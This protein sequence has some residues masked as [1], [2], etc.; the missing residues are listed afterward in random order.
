[1][2]TTD[3]LLQEIK[4]EIK[5][6]RTDMGKRMDD[7]E[8][9]V[10]VCE[11]ATKN[12]IRTMRRQQATINELIERMNELAKTDA[13]IWHSRDNMVIGLDCG[14]AY[15][16]FRELG[17]TRYDALK[18]LEATGVLKRGYGQ[19]LTK[20]IRINNKD[21]RVIAIYAE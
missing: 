14:K 1:M 12:A 19:N 9:R 11:R 6:L 3:N 17:Y 16:T 2:N 8:G 5:S 10:D 13:A 21:L 18:A 15:D 20:G 4:S 7:V